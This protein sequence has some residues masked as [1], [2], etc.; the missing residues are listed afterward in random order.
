MNPTANEA[1]PG[2]EPDGAISDFF[3]D[4]TRRLDAPTT[5]NQRGSSD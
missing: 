3:M 5:Y 2:T 4:N 1:P